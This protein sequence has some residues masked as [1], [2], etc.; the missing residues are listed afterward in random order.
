MLPDLPD[1]D[2]WIRARLQLIGARI[3]ARRMRQNLT[4]Q[5]VFLAAR[6]DRG[7][8]QALEAGRGNPTF[9]TL[10]RVAY[11]LDMPLED[12]VR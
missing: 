4:Q 2:E 3:Q 1:D 8:L 6:I 11:A 7:T 9:A 10:M 5:A 12:L